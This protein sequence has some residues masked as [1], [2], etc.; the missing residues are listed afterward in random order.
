MISY[1]SIGDTPISRG[2]LQPLIFWI[3]DTV[4]FPDSELKRYDGQ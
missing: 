2:L 3:E 4:D 1:Q